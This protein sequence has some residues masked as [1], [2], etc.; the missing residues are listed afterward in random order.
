M[1][2]NGDVAGN[3]GGLARAK[4]ACLEKE[5]LEQSLS[6]AWGHLVCV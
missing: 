5:D 2:E 1:N 4:G 6:V 3:T